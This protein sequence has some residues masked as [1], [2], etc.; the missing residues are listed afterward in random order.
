MWVRL[1]LTI[2]DS[3]QVVLEKK[4]LMIEVRH[5]CLSLSVSNLN[6]DES[7][8]QEFLGKQ[9]LGLQSGTHTH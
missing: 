4:C 5:L 1:H 9:K 7:P 2:D 3:R 6:I 8:I